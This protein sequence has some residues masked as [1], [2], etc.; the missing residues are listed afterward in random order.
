MEEWARKLRRSGYSVTTR[1]QV[2]KEAVEKYEPGSGNKLPGDYIRYLNGLI[3]T[4][5][6]QTKSLPPL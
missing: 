4:K 5:L 6:I 1:H 3:G 2:I